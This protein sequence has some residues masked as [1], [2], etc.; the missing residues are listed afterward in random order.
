M[1]T[2]FTAADQNRKGGGKN[3]KS[4]AMVFTQVRIFA[5]GMVEWKR[6]R[7]FARYPHFMVALGLLHW[8]YCVTD[9]NMELL[10]HGAFMKLLSRRVRGES[11]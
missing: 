9:H 11:K 6:L 5:N 7:V 10:F 8:R 3:Y 1:D 2:I 4:I